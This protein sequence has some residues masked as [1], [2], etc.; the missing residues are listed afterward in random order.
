MKRK[1]LGHSGLWV[2]ELCLGCMTFGEPLRGGHPWTLPEAESRPLI[3]MAY[4]AGIDFFDTA[5][6]YSDG[7]SEEILGNYLWDLAPRQEII[8]ATKVHGDPRPERQGLSRRLI[9]QQIDASLK[10]LRTDHVDLYQVH[11][12]DPKTPIEE[13][14]EALHDV[15]KVSNCN[16]LCVRFVSSQPMSQLF[17]FLDI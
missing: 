5:N 6:V 1:Q 12:W 14:M 8:L 16:D 17:N 2:S 11:R 4:E 15:V 13:T 9:M 10:R 3:R 7:S